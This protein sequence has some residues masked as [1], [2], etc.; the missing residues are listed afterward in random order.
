MPQNEIPQGKQVEDKKT[1]SPS[2]LP[3]LT[4]EEAKAKLLGGIIKDPST[5]PDLE[6]VEVLIYGPPGAGKT[7]SLYTLPRPLLI[8]D[9]DN[10]AEKT[11]PAYGMSKEAF[12]KDV[13]VWKMKER[14]FERPLIQGVLTGISKG[15]QPKGYKEIADM[16]N[17]L[18]DNNQNYASIALDSMTPLADHMIALLMNLQ[19][20]DQMRI[21][22][23]GFFLAMMRECIYVFNSINANTVICAHEE[24]DDDTKRIVPLI[25]GSMKFRILAYYSEAYRA[26]AITGSDG[27]TTWSFAT[28]SSSRFDAKSFITEK[29][30]IDTTFTHLF[31][32]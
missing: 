14:L 3:R 22:D 23:W 4:S 13:H 17:L 26:S 2:G 10:K 15:P 27:K 28:K 6:K 9:L 29:T 30:S 7:T 21:Q 32:K 25:P 24:V 16:I 18:A 19:K 8:L 5:N 31:K 20:V 12:F 11:R 1:T